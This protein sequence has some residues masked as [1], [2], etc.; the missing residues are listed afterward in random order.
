MNPRSIILGVMIVAVSFIGATLA[1]NVLWPRSPATL[2]EGRPAL[3]AVPPLKPLAGV[4]TVLAPAAITMSAIGEALEAQAP[5]NLAG[6][7]SGAVSSLMPDADIH[8]TIARG[9]L[10]VSGQPDA[11]VVTTPLSGAFQARGTIN[12]TANAVGSIIGAV[13]GGA[14]QQVQNLVGRTFDQRA[15]IRGTV[16][17]TARPSI[18]PNWR[19]TPNLAAQI[20][21]AD[22]VVPVAGVVKL[23]V[24][25]EVKPFLDNAVH[26]QTTALETRLRNDPFIENAARNEWS[27]LCRSISLGAA[28]QGLPNLWLEVRPTHAIAAQPKIDGNTV[29]LFVGVRAE[30]R[31]VPAETKPDCPFPEQLEIVPQANEG[32][33]DITV[34]IDIPFTEVSRLVDAQ[35]RDKTFSEDASGK[36][37]ITVKQAEIAPS[38]DRLLISLLV[39]VKRHGFFSVGADA[40]LHV[41]GR[42]VLDQ[43]HQLLRFTDVKLDVQSKAAFGLLGEAAQAAVPYLQRMLAEKVVID[44]K[45]FAA[46]AKKR[47]ASAVTNFTSQAGGLTA[48]VNVTALRLTDIAYDDKALRVIADADGAVNVMISSVN[49]Q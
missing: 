5:R 43:E 33:L 8:W 20:N 18:A 41:W 7:R 40:T 28:G 10:N 31:I 37:A 22:V 21:V 6:K 46:D 11:L 35:I 14:G 30:T 13:A 47:I 29:T 44:L 23:S 12:N 24:A 1:M 4:S 3:A 48:D 17:A 45:P 42:P 2:K 36:Y 38:G 9:P 39:S 27:K 26:E 34:P 49:M 25:K 19:L 15:D 16:M 32:T